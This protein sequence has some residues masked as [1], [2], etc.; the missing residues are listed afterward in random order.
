M[1]SVRPWSDTWG[2]RWVLSEGCA[3]LYIH[4]IGGPCH[5]ATYP[6]K[7]ATPLVTLRGGARY[8]K[9]GEGRSVTI[10]GRLYVEYYYDYIEG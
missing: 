7:E 1:S 8:R 2:W 4:L 5:D 9:S 6:V 10:N 3:R